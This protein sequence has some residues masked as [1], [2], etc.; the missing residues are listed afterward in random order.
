MCIEKVIKDMSGLGNTMDG[1][2]DGYFWANY[3]KEDATPGYEG[4]ATS[5]CSRVLNL[6]DPATLAKLRKTAP[7]TGIVLTPKSYLIGGKISHV[8]SN[9]TALGPAQRDGQLY[10]PFPLAYCDIATKLFPEGAGYNHYGQYTG[11]T[12]FDKVAWGLNV[13]RL[14]E[15]KAKYHHTHPRHAH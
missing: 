2:T 1:H 6:N 8:A 3:I 10:I 5:G 11:D 13:P 4:T 7:L 12:D 9:A 14:Q 15:I